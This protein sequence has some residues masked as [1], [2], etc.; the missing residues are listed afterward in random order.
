MRAKSKRFI[1]GASGA[2][3]AIA[4]ALVLV[5]TGSGA[6]TGNSMNAGATARSITTRNA[7]SSA[8]PRAAQAKTIAL[9]AAAS[10]GDKAPTGIEY[11]GL[12]TRNQALA[13][14]DGFG[15]MGG[16]LGRATGYYLLVEHGHFTDTS[17][18]I[19]GPGNDDLTGTVIVLVV[20]AASGDVTD[21]GLLHHASAVHTSSLGTM[22][23]VSSS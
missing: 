1:V 10:Y 23:P 20:D 8:N 15:R 11:S 5:T 14:V 4:A 2:A 13:A 22:T 19:V 21:S 18:S 6:T 12:V 3:A 7:V 9:Q 16:A 17:A